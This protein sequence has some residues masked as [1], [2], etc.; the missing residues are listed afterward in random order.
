MQGR[1]G[2]NQAGPAV[3]A[4]PSPRWI[5]KR[6]PRWCGM[7]WWFKA[8]CALL[9][10]L[11]VSGCVGHGLPSGR[12]PLKLAWTIDDYWVRSNFPDQEPAIAID[13]NRAA[14]GFAGEWQSDSPGT[15]DVVTRVGSSSEVVA[16][17]RAPEAR[18]GDGFGESVA[19]FGPTLAVLAKP[20]NGT[21]DSTLYL[22][23]QDGN[24]WQLVDMPSTPGV[25]PQEVYLGGANLVVLAGYPRTDQAFAAR[26][27]AAGW[28]RFQSVDLRLAELPAGDMGRP[29]EIRLALNGDQ[30]A[31]GIP[32]SYPGTSICSESWRSS[33][34]MTTHT[35][36][37]CSRGAVELFRWNGTWQSEQR[38]VGPDEPSSHR[39]GSF[40][41]VAGD[42]LIIGSDARGAADEANTVRTFRKQVN[43]WTEGPPVT[44]PN[45]QI[46]EAMIATDGHHVLLHGSIRTRWDP[47]CYYCARDDFLVKIDVFTAEGEL[48][49]LEPEGID[50]VSGWEA[51]GPWQDGVWEARLGCRQDRGPNTCEGKLEPIRFWIYA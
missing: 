19:L 50:G 18:P 48:R 4:G 23:E 41:D 11:I 16:Q 17:L 28:S 14:L 22:F 2:E 25:H 46:D 7:A 47:V 13:G 35:T 30:M 38:I 31:I 26:R 37:R 32:E 15:V 43:I 1:P 34:T 27:A 45:V 44:F 40:L 8:G 3:G 36:Q 39:F 6:R 42:V 49:L 10:C 33:G 24:A 9:T 29:S 5:Q 51:F 20:R 12:L 21:G